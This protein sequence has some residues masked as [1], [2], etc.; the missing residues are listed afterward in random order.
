MEAEDV[1][2]LERIPDPP[3]P[4]CK[5]AQKVRHAK[6]DGTAPAIGGSLIVRA[7]DQTAQIVM[8]DHGMTDLR[9][10]VREG[11]AMAPKLAPRLQAM[12]DNMFTRPKQRGN[13]G[14]GLFGLPTQ[15]V[16]N[17]AV[18][19]RFNTPDTINPVAVQHRA[20]D[21][22]PVHIIAGDG[23]KGR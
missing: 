6:F 3:C 20:K 18:K 4:T 2:T 8:E 9:S 5:K 1:E 19:G 23:V 15:A 12:A 16:I 11:E 17:A 22:P 13:P 21:R 7:V 14:A 10:D